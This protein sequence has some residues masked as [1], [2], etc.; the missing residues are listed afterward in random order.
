MRVPSIL[1]MLGAA[2]LLYL[3]ARELFSL[4]FSLIATLIFCLHPIVAFES[5]EIRPYAFAVF[6]VNAAIL[7]LLRMRRSNSL[8]LAALFGFLSALIVSFHYLFALV[9]PAFV[10]VFFVLKKV[11]GK[12]VWRQCGMAFVV[13]VLFFLPLIPGIEHLFRTKGA[14][15]YE[16]SPH[17]GNLVWTL[18]AGGPPLLSFC[19]VLLAAALVASFRSDEPAVPHSPE[20]WRVPV[21]LSLGLIPLL[22]LYCISVGTPIHMFA[23]RHQLDAIPGLALCWTLLVERFFLK[24]SF[25]L[26]FCVLLT[27][28][29]AFHS[30]HSTD[31]KEQRV[32]EKYALNYVDKNASMDKASVLICSGFVESHHISSSLDLRQ[33]SWYYAPLSYYKLSVPVVP[34]PRDLNVQTKQI[35]SRFLKQSEQMRQRFLALRKM[36]VACETL[37]WLTQQASPNFTVRSLGTF[38]TI[39]VLEFD[40]KFPATPPAGRSLGLPPRH[41]AKAASRPATR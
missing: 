39:K 12:A 2:W 15:V 28:A 4:E 26:L 22:L 3:A 29:T 41:G 31:F 8:P 25:R 37:D 40:P 19:G 27:A 36:D 38:D 1:T 24:G 32:T 17:L 18:V 10:V 5:T 20:R 14:H 7:I 34:L 21:C 23:Y 16:T 13:F 30:L 11:D 35:G 9:L 33:A 6:F